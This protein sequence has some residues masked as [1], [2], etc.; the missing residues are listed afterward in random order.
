MISIKRVYPNRRGVITGGYNRGTTAYL[1][2]KSGYR[3][4]ASPCREKGHEY[5]SRVYEGDDDDDDDAGVN[6]PSD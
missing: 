2:K 4:I 3:A 5:T 6:A 1:N